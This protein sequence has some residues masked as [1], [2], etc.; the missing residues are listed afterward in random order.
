MNL[1]HT[2][3]EPSATH[4][5]WRSLI[6]KGSKNLLIDLTPLQLDILVSYI[7]Q[8][9]KWNKAYNLT[10]IRDPLDMIKLHVLDSLAIIKHL[11]TL[12]G[13]RFIDVGTG[14]G[15]PGMILAIIWPQKVIHLLD[16]NGK[17]TRF[18]TQFKHLHQLTNVEVL[19]QRC[20]AYI[21]KKT[22]DVVLS[23]AFASIKEM[24]NGCRHLVGDDGQFVA[25][26][27]TYPQQE[28]DAMPANYSLLNCEILQVPG[29]KAQRHLLT[30]KKTINI[31]HL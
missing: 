25:M 31:G 10:A 8:L 1:N 22:Y 30:I 9:V 6:S 7:E 4:E 19:N 29:V 3:V 16:T 5:Q 23:R 21:P 15:L 24:L 26:K 17:K 2:I 18:L 14:A 13:Q 11:S 20:E 27:G 12:N 28:L